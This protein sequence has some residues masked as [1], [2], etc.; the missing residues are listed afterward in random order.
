MMQG[1]CAC[2]R[3]P[4]GLYL[5]VHPHHPCVFL[6]FFHFPDLTRRLTLHSISASLDATS[7]TICPQPVCRKPFHSRSCI[8]PD[9]TVQGSV[10]SHE[11]VS[12]LLPWENRT[13]TNK[14]AHETGTHQ[15]SLTR[16]EYM[17]VVMV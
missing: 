15:M 16:F 4:Q 11:A 1:I 5:H 17:E 10:S 9:Q 6:C 3:V 12:V 7:S 14:G 13:H 2:Q 8:S